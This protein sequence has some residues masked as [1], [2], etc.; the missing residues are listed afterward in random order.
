MQDKDHKI[1]MR[2]LAILIGTAAM[3]LVAMIGLVIYV[4]PFFQYHKPL[5]GFP[6]LIDHQLSQNPGMA[7]T[8]DYD[9]V[10]LGSSM[11]VNFNTDWFR[12]LFDLKTAKLSYNGAYPKDQANIM[13]IIFSHNK[14]VKKVFLGVDIPAYS[15][16]I[17]ETKYPIPA[18][19]YDDSYSNDISY[20]LNKDVILNYILRPLADPKDQ[21]KIPTMY[22][23]WWTDEYFNKEYVLRDYKAPDIVAQEVKEDTF[24]PYLQANLDENICPYLE[25][26]PE[27]EFVV[28]Y[29]PYSILYWYGVNRENKLDATLAEYRAMTERLLTYPNVR[30]FLFSDVEWIIEDLDHYADYD[31]YHKDINRYMAECFKNGDC[32]I[33]DKKQLAAR[34]DALR[35]LTSTYDY[36]SI[37]R[38]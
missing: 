31:H 22:S 3:I 29:P 4:D 15:A 18:Y 34:M 16:D 8:W 38:D 32:E 21:T 10:L 2:F 27:T 6:Y 24:L 7:K 36:E 13:D 37:F 28:F 23:L 9:S 17:E 14:G 12:E 25:A 1:H 19:L 35:E 33:R 5:D 26:H 11:T 20:V 30:V